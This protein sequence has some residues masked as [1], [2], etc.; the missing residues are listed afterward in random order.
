MPAKQSLS[1][2][3]EPRASIPFEDY[4]IDCA[5]SPDGTQL[6]V[7]GG[8]GKVALLNTTTASPSLA[9]I[10]EHLLGTLAIAWQPRAARFA[11][12]GQDGGVALWDATAARELKRWKPAIGAPQALQYSPSG[13]LLAIAAGK[14]VSLWSPEGEKVHAFAAAASTPVALAF[15]K[16]GADIGVALNG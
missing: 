2:A 5:W 8:E 4:V 6:A 1:F 15:D 13:E 12:A 10:G 7:A 3:L 16:P 11:S 9:V 14:T